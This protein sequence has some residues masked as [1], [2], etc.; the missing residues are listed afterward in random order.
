MDARGA[1]L[2][3]V[4]CFFVVVPGAVFGN[5]CISQDYHF[6]MKKISCLHACF[7]VKLLPLYF[8]SCSYIKNVTQ[9][10]RLWDPLP[11]SVMLKSVF[12]L[13]LFTQCPSPQLL[14]VIYGRFSRCTTVR[15]SSTGLSLVGPTR[16]E[17]ISFL[18]TEVP[19]KLKI[20]G[21]LVKFEKYGTPSIYECSLTGSPCLCP[22]TLTNTF[23][24]NCF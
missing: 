22:I 20:K 14:D 21:V 2:V 13:L 19:L 5:H 23:V 10:W 12:N 11:F 15:G 7:F 4:Q 6:L 9:I 1:L 16:V 18:F 3:L 17:V 24:F 8:F